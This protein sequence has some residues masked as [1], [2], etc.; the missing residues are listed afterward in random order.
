MKW[1][2]KSLQNV[3]KHPKR[4][5]KCNIA[6]TDVKIIDRN[7]QKIQIV[8]PSPFIQVKMV[9]CNPRKAHRVRCTVALSGG[10]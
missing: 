1:V 10:E 7:M 9:I 3:H 8:L 4:K 2:K 6:T 5:I